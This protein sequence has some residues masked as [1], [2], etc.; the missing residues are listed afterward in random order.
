MHEWSIL[1]PRPGEA[2]DS[3]LDQFGLLLAALYKWHKE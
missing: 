3:L 1:Y 2:N